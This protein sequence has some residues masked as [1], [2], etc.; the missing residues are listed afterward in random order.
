MALR[1]RSPTNDAAPYDGVTFVQF[2]TDATI[3]GERDPAAL[4]G[5]LEP[6]LIRR[7]TSLWSCN[8]GLTRAAAK[9]EDKGW[10]EPSRHSTSFQASAGRRIAS[11]LAEIGR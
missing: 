2:V 4:A 8:A 3:M 9:R 11:S 1:R 6:R 10:L 5:R 7:A